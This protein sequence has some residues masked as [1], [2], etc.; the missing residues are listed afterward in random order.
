[1]K[2]IDYNS[3]DVIVGASSAIPEA[4]PVMALKGSG[5][6]WSPRDRDTEVSPYIFFQVREND[7]FSFKLRYERP[8]LINICRLLK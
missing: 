6:Y 4:R 2:V 1:M 7:C 8:L 5:A 3:S